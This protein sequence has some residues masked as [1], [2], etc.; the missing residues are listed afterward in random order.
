[1]KIFTDLT[2]QVTAGLVQ[3]NDYTISNTGYDVIPMN[4]NLI[5]I[6][7]DGLYQYDYTNLNDIQLMSMIATGQCPE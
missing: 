6:G 1:M 3:G 7:D 4:G 2:N 5:L